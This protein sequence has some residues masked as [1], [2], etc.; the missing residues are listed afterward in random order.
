[1]IIILNGP[2]N[3]GKTTVAKILQKNIPNT[4]H[5][6]VDSLRDF[7]YWMKGEQGAYELSIENGVLITKNFV[8][9][10]LNVIF[11]Y[12]IEDKDYKKIMEML[13]DI[14]TEIYVFTLNPE[15]KAALSNRG[16][17]E[18]NE[19]EK[20]R[21]KYHYKVGTNIPSFGQ[22]IDNTKQTPEGT[23][24]VILQRLSTKN[25]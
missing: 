6:E 15:L 21:I 25:K 22:V 2:R 14:N 9:H 8:K 7:V 1:M 23:A 24:E 12:L 16:T 11:T 13:K 5:G 20:D 17:R 10:G 4:A 19:Q 3:S 18:L